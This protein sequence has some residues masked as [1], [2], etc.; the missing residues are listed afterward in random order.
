MKGL[1]FLPFSEAGLQV[2]RGHAGKAPGVL[3]GPA[4]LGSLRTVPGVTL[5]VSPV[6]SGGIGRVGWTEPLGSNWGLLWPPP[7]AL[8]ASSLV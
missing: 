7:P 1:S 2:D 5:R 3:P 8:Q 6:T 4:L